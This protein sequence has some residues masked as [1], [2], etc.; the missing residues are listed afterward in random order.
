MGLEMVDDEECPVKQK[1]F[2]ERHACD[3]RNLL[4]DAREIGTGDNRDGTTSDHM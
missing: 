3:E 2:G 4:E 1:Q